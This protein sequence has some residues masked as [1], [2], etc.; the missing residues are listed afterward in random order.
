VRQLRGSV[1]LP[2]DN[3]QVLLE[4]SQPTKEKIMKIV[5]ARITDM[6]KS[7]FDPMPEVHA[8]FEDGSEKMLFSFYPDEISFGTQE[9]V[10]LTEQEAHD[11]F[12]KKDVAYLRS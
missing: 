9:F 3:C 1:V 8:T 5:S 4:Y 2:L 12:R 11:L 6:P 7:F 10:G